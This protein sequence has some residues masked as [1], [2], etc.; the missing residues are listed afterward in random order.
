MFLLILSKIFLY[1]SK[2]KYNPTHKGKYRRLTVLSRETFP[3]GICSLFDGCNFRILALV[4]DSG[5]LWYLCVKNSPNPYLSQSATDDNEIGM[6]CQ[7]LLKLLNTE[8]P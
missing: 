2:N 3:I 1:I 7:S 5:Q 8:Y 4:Y 6:Q